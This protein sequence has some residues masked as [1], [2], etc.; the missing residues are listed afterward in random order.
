MKSK[1]L[2]I[3]LFLI[4]SISCLGQDRSA[5][6][7]SKKQ[8]KSTSTINNNVDDIK[9]YQHNNI[10]NGSKIYLH[11]EGGERKIEPKTAK[12]QI[13][14]YDLE[15]VNMMIQAYKTKIKYVSSNPEEDKISIENG[16]YTTINN[17]L[18]LLFSRKEELEKKSS[19]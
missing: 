15:Q 3:M 16:W 10:Q 18:E 5:I 2:L 12:E 8:I 6:S 14:S 4:Y 7:D 9:S 11:V 1:T 19:K 13:A 17:E